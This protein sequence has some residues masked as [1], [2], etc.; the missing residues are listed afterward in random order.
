MM[1]QV[2]VFWF[3]TPCTVH[4]EDRGTM[5]LRNIGI[6]PQHHTATQL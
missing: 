2:E 3:V 4:P 6:L 1:F 5:V